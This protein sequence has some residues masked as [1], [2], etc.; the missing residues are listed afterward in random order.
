MSTAYALTAHEKQSG[1]TRVSWAE[2]LI[3]Q[4]PETHDGRNS[5]L[6]NYGLSR[7]AWD[8]REERGT[9]FD[10]ETKAA[11]VKCELTKL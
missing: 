10:A 6:L 9:S 5:W 4:L 8:L 1:S 3:L 11:V 2:S 7:E